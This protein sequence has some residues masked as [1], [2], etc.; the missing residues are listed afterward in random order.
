[1]TGILIASPLRYVIV[2]AMIDIMCGLNIPRV[3]MLFFVR[4]KQLLSPDV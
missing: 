2:H 4:N 1:M 3:L